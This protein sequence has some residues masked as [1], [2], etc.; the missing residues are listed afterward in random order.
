MQNKTENKE[1][2]GHKTPSPK[3]KE[4]EVFV[5]NWDVNGKNLI[6]A[7][8]APDEH[9]KGTESYEW[10]DGNFYLECRWNRD[11]GKYS[12][13]GLGVIGYDEEKKTFV[14]YNFDNLGYTRMYMFNHDGDTWKMNGEHE[15]AM[16]VFSNGGNTM[17][18]DWEVRKEGEDWKPLCH[19]EQTKR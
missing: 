6:T 1:Q 2:S 7:P 17:V 12:H 11:F 8:L 9:I 14:T 4:L 5:G 10:M 19:L 13:I 15:R 16:Y 18:I 3:L